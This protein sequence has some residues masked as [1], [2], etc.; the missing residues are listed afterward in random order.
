LHGCL[1]DELAWLVMLGETPARAI[2]A[3]TAWPAR[4]LGL[5]EV[6][7]TLEPGK[8]ADVIAVDGDPLAD[9]AAL[10][11]VRLVVSRGR[12]VHLQPGGERS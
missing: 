8:I 11:R 9:I 6:V 2:Q 3:A 1:A 5:G 4:A 10:G 12:I 7:G